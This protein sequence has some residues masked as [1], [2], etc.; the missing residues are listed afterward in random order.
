[1]LLGTRYKS[2]QARTD[3]QNVLD[4]WNKQYEEIFVE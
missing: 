3:I 1:M 4:I 2:N